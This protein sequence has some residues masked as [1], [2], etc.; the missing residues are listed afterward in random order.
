MAPAAPNIDGVL[1]TSLYVDDLEGAARFYEEAMGFAPLV[2][3]ARLCAYD[4]GRRSVL[5]LFAR[6]TTGET[7]PLAG[8]AIPPHEG[9]GRLHL[10][11]AVRAEDLASW[12]TRLADHGVSIEARMTWPRGG[13]SLY[14]R[15]PE[16]NLVELATP[17]LWA[18]Y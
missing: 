9:A 17:G 1:E 12:E 4:C 8:G 3:D 10:A 14:F 18:N 6:G 5:L 16:G 15:D 11:F 7:A 2:R 13:A